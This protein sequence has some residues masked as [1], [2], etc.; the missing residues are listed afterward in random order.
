[1][2]LS[3]ESFFAWLESTAIARA[4]AESLPLTASLSAIHLLG[5]TLVLGGALLGNLKRLNVLLPRSA[6]ADVV[7]PAN[8]AIAIGLAISVT[9]GT[10]LF[11]ARATTIGENGTFALKMLL[12]LAATVVHFSVGLLHPAHE[13]V[14]RPRLGAAASL[15][16]W[17]ALAI[18]ACAFILLE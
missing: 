12:L 10:L 8:R 4:V 6:A 18:T 15:S 17:I 14:A 3:A 1:M 13:L 5:F 7:R 2:V 9:T 16:L 11:A